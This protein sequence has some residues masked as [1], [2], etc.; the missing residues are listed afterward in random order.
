MLRKDVIIERL[1]LRAFFLFGALSRKWPKQ[2]RTAITATSLTA[3]PQQRLSFQVSFIFCKSTQYRFFTGPLVWGK[4]N[5][6]SEVQICFSPQ[7]PSFY[8]RETTAVLVSSKR[9]ARIELCGSEGAVT[10]TGKSWFALLQF[11][12]T[13]GRRLDQS[14]CVVV[15]SGQSILK[16]L[17]QRLHDCVVQRWIH[18]TNEG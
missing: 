14:R 17:A 16:E 11:D 8:S 15:G 18:G 12:K 2:P 13:R 3:T 5:L 10:S 1:A 9:R 6:T 4:R 7:G